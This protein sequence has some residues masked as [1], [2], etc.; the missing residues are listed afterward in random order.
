M[1]RISPEKVEK[2]IKL[3]VRQFGLEDGFKRYR[4][5]KTFNE[6]V[7]EAVVRHIKK[8]TMKGRQ[9]FVF[10]DSAAAR[11]HV[12][13]QRSTIIQDINEQYGEYIVEEI[14]LK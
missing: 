2:A 7:G 5:M 4:V 9:L 13:M 6:I 8:K 14:I 10:F 1:E 12:F 11:N 3:F